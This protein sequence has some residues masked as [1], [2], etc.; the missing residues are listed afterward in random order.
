MDLTKETHL[1][2]E[3]EEANKGPVQDKKLE[4]GEGEDQGASIPEPEP[5]FKLVEENP[6]KPVISNTLTEAF[7]RAVQKALED[8]T[9]PSDAERKEMEEALAAESSSGDDWDG[10]WEQAASRAGKKAF[11]RAVQKSLQETIDVSNGKKDED[12]D[13]DEFTPEYLEKMAGEEKIKKQKQ[14]K[15]YTTHTHSYLKFP[16]KIVINHYKRK[17]ITLEPIKKA[18]LDNNS[19]NHDCTE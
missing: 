5:S 2:L 11:Q 9:I 8:P 14:K 18:R 12:E 1:P 17:K 7:S 4:E 3:R 15:N 6:D 13:W 10:D 16:S 19:D